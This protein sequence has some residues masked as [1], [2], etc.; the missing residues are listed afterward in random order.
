MLREK[1]DDALLT[2]SLS[3]LVDAAR[4]GDNLIPV[5]IDSVKAYAT[6]GE[7]CESLRGV[8]GEYNSSQVV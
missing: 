4:A 8:Y 7:I 5:L 3:D 2:Q 1:R 6:I